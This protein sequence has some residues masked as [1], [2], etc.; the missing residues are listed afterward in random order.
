MIHYFEECHVLW[1]SSKESVGSIM[2]NLSFNLKWK[3]I[4]KLLWRQPSIMFNQSPE[5]GV[6]L[7]KKCKIAV[8]SFIIMD[9]FNYSLCGAEK[10]ARCHHVCNGVQLAER[11]YWPSSPLSGFW[12]KKKQEI[13]ADLSHPS[14]HP[15][16]HLPS[17]EKLR[18][19]MT[20]SYLLPIHF[21]STVTLASKNLIKIT[22][23]FTHT[24][25]TQI[26]SIL[27]CF[28]YK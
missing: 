7:F 9:F 25:H 6:T 27:Y 8:Q 5:G 17:G 3:D 23:I 4:L 19:N 18:S 28:H 11:F 14:C 10:L 26:Y 15:L 22:T 20:K 13:T 21:L 16:N 24:G 1:S 2:K 12:N